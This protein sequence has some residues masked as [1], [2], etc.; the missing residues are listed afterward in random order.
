MNPSR[1]AI[2]PPHPVARRAPALPGRIPATIKES[3]RFESGG[4]GRLFT[5][6]RGVRNSL[7]GDSKGAMMGREMATTYRVFVDDGDFRKRDQY[8]ARVSARQQK[9]AN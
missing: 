4:G 5:L 6:T 1:R 7:T 3:P 9:G 8:H 2:T